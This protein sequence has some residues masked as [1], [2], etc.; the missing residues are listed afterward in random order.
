M[1]ALIYLSLK[2]RQ[3]FL[4][5]TQKDRQTNSISNSYIDV[6]MWQNSRRMLNSF[7]ELIFQRRSYKKP[8]GTGHTVG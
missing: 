3:A 6:E 4:I 5:D 7:V 1:M 8:L 2:F